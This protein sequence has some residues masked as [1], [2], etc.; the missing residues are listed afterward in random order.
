MSPF[1]GFHEG[2]QRVTSVPAQFFSEL[3]PEID[4]LAELKVCLYAI[5]Y[6]DRMEGKLRYLRHRNFTEDERL[7]QGLGR[8]PE[9][10][11]T[12]LADGLER[13]VQRGFLLRALPDDQ[14]PDQVIYFLNSPRGRAAAQAL[15]NGE[16]SPEADAGTR[17]AQTLDMERPNIYRLYEDNIGPLTPLIAEDLREA[18]RQYPSDWIEDAIRIAVQNNVRRWRYIEAILRSWQEKGRHEDRRNVEED[19]RRYIEGEFGQYIQH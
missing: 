2:K 14:T 4:H 10:A 17:A 13:A 6:L 3:L 5:W 18:E 11:L 16:W 1:A 7:L 15:Q 19:S 9:E 12:A 8:T